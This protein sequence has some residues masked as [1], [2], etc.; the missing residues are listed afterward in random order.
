MAVHWSLP[1]WM[2]PLLLV[3]AAGAVAWTVA[4]YRDTRPAVSPRLRRLLS[5]LR[6]AALVLL[7]LGL[8][9]PVV[10]QLQRR[11][12]PAELVIV[13]ED[14]ASMELAA[15][16][17]DS[18]ESRWQ[19]A[20]AVAGDLQ[21]RFA[22]RQPPVTTRLLRGNGLEGIQE[23]ALDDPVVPAPRRHG[24][25]L[26][27]LAAQARRRLIGHPVRAVVLIGDGQE[28]ASG[29]PL[30][31]PSGGPAA[32]PLHAVGV[33]D[34][35]GPADRLLRDVRYPETVFQGD[36]VIIEATVAHRFVPGAGLEPL[37]VRLTGPRGVVAADTLA[38]DGPVIGV[39]LSFTPREAGLQAYRLEVS[40]LDNE[41]FLENNEATLAID[42]RQERARV[43]LLAPVPGWD[44]RFLAQ[45]AAAETRLA[46]SVV[47]PTA[48]GLAYADSL[49]PWREP[50]DAAAWLAWDAVVLTGWSGILAGLDWGDLAQAVEQGLG[51]VV[52]P[53]PVTGSG[54]PAPFPPPAELARILPVDASAWRWQ[55]G[56][57]QVRATAPTHPVLE[58][59]GT[60][61]DGLESL[62]PLREAARVRPQPAAEVLVTAAARAGAGA[63]VE[64]PVLVVGGAGAARAAWFG[65]RHLWEWAFWEPGI[66]RPE[67]G[68]GEQP[69]R[70]LAR[71]L[72]V[73]AALGDDGSGLSFTGGPGLFQEGEKV[74]VG[75]RWRDIRGQA[76]LDRRLSLVLRSDAA[77]DSA[78][79]RTFAMAPVAGD[80]GAFAADLPPLPPGAYT[81]GLAGAGDPPVE[82]P[83][84]GLIVAETSVER[85][86]VRQD[87]RRLDLLASREGGAVH[88]A[89]AAEAPATLVAALDELDWSGLPQERRSRS[90]LAGGWP[91]L[92][93]VVL[94]LSC[95]WFLRRRHGLL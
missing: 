35:E 61:A 8:A 51:L 46:L 14:S 75:A 22:R 37:V 25:D 73:W 55:R 64:V 76:V 7:L 50:A 70:R 9:G 67:D 68:G 29:A 78:L 2:W 48:K 90:E 1:A 80:P 77:G 10:S 87:R 65:G 31:A 39:E 84:A 93:L 43:L 89:A 12:A 54:A 15:D 11:D 53:G 59:V 21:S 3:V 88:A 33:G 34:V 17:G 81:V 32:A 27:A 26:N 82:G 60:G 6:G 24:T 79:V 58:G 69:G 19:R 91:F 44:V 74:R 62:P 95:E 13:L 86:Q 56:P 36:E 66:A 57:L 63:E 30:A 42:V 18:E 20:L 5:A 45:A 71:N 72:I 52:V 28:T 47:H 4:L 41:R 83:T 16:G 49:T 23:F 94:L 92:A 85:G 40:A 38:A